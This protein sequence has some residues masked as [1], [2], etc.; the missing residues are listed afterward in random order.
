MPLNARPVCGRVLI[1]TGFCLQHVQAAAPAPDLVDQ[2][3]LRDDTS[4]LWLRLWLTKSSHF[5]QAAA[6][7]PDLMDLRDQLEAA[8]RARSGASARMGL[9]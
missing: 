2:R 8:R 4:R 3:E 9:G 6:P 1:M 5:A 7:A